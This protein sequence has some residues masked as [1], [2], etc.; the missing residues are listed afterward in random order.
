MKHLSKTERQ[1]IQLL[2]KKKYSQREIAVVLGRNPST[3]SRELAR[4]LVCGE[5]VADKAHLKSYQRRYWV[6]KELPR[7]WDSQWRPFRA[8]LEEKLSQEHPW[9]LEQIAHSWSSVHPE[10]SISSA[11]LYRFIDRYEYRLKKF[12]NHQRYHIKRRTNV[13][14]RVM[15]PNRIW[16]DDRPKVVD[17]RSTMG[18]WEGDTLGSKRGETSNLLGSIERKSRFLLVAKMP[19]R[20]PA[21]AAN[22]LKKWN[23]I[24]NFKSL[25]LDNGIEFKQHEKIGCKTYFC[26]PYSSWEKGQIEYA[27]RLLRRLVPK[28]SSLQHVS[29]H[30]LQKFVDQLNHTPRK[31]LDWKTPHQVFFNIQPNSLFYN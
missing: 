29:H 19:N 26:H 22:K 27:M 12:L 2:R 7:L 10:T 11:T 20:K 24:Y 4:N 9:S 6:A 18:H 8:F 30:K 31:C 13:T 15:I 28:K 17:S 21:L 3:I 16:I 23:K 1:E 5:Y 14:K 25:T